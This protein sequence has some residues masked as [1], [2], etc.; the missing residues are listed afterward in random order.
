MIGDSGG[1]LLCQRCDSCNFY[2]AGVTSFGKGCAEKGYYGVY[3]KVTAYEDWI[4][5]HL[6]TGKVVKKTCTKYGT[7]LIY[8]YPP[9]LGE[10]L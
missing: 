3:T 7:F 1:P 8:S 10:R 6:S 5:K 4:A 2:V 9:R